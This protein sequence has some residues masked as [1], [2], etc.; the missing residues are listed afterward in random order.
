MTEQLHFH[1]SL[2]CTEEGKGNPLH[3]YCLENP[4]DGGA[5]WA[6]V[7]G[8]ARSRTQLKRLSSSSTRGILWNKEV[9]IMGPWYQSI[10]GTVD[11]H[12]LFLRRL[13]P[14]GNTSLGNYFDWDIGKKYLHYENLHAIFHFYRYWHVFL[15]KGIQI[16]L[17]THTSK[18]NGALKQFSEFLWLQTNNP[19]WYMH[20]V[21]LTIIFRV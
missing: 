17:W 6:A 1:F 18:V 9:T 10:P 16:V 7:Y 20:M 14:V 8:V 3:C 21:K 11:S 13:P 19:I 15:H 5:W 12:C 4:R 2:S